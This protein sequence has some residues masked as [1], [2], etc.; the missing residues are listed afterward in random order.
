MHL[1][2]CVGSWTPREAGRSQ[3]GCVRARKCT[4]W[5]MVGLWLCVYGSRVPGPSVHTSPELCS[6]CGRAQVWRDGI[7]RFPLLT[8]MPAHTQ[9]GARKRVLAHP[10]AFH[11]PACVSAVC[12][13]VC[14]SMLLRRANPSLPRLAPPA[15]VPVVWGPTRV[16]GGWPGETAGSIGG[17]DVPLTSVLSA[18]EGIGR[19]LGWEGGTSFR[20]SKERGPVAVIISNSKNPGH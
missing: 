18:W 14:L 7:S 8:C 15:Q 5:E 11:R 12:V 20:R 17:A 16:L 19:G 3:P 1:C 10:D 4:V 6:L 9:A 13:C 2:A